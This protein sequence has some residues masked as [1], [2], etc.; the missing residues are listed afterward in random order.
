MASRC[1]RED[2]AHRVMFRELERFIPAHPPCGD[3]ICTWVALLGRATGSRSTARMEARLNDAWTVVG[4]AR[5]SITRM[6]HVLLPRRRDI[7]AAVAFTVIA[8]T[9]SWLVS[10]IQNVPLI[11]DWTYAWSVE[12]LQETHRLAVFDWS[13]HYPLTQILWAWPFMALRGFSFFTLRLSAV[14]IGKTDLRSARLT[15]S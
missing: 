15:L 8:A 4:R 12:H 3:L 10:P 13:V 11:D 5:C 1:R 2:A 7:L 14:S 9:A 6:S